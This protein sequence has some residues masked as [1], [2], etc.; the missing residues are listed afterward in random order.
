MATY[1][2]PPSLPPYLLPCLPDFSSFTSSSQSPRPPLSHNCTTSFPLIH[3]AS[4]FPSNPK[5]APPFQSKDCLWGLAPCRYFLFTSFTQYNHKKS[6]HK[7]KQSEYL[8]P[9]G[10]TVHIWAGGPGGGPSTAEIQRDIQVVRT[11]SSVYGAFEAE[12]T[13]VIQW[14]TCLPRLYSW[15]SICYTT[16]HWQKTLVIKVNKVNFVHGNNPVLHCKKKKKINSMRSIFEFS[17]LSLLTWVNVNN[18]RQKLEK[19]KSHKSNPVDRMFCV[20]SQHVFFY[21]VETLLDYLVQVNHRWPKVKSGGLW[22]YLTVCV[23]E[24]ARNRRL[25]TSRL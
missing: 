19:H 1:L 5:T 13:F 17:L 11:I 7:W 20:F 12:N 4:F 3:R 9:H 16:L 14:D 6:S 23:R 15:L 22:Q 8:R 18:I 10:W 24:R 2:P 25:F 21:S